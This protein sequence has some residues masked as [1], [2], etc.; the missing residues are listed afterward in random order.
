MFYF[1]CNHGLRPKLLFVWRGQRQQRFMS[2]R[3]QYCHDWRKPEF[4]TAGLCPNFRRRARTAPPI[5]TGDCGCPEVTVTRRRAKK[6]RP[7]DDRSTDSDWPTPDP[8]ADQ[9]CRSIAVRNGLDRVTTYLVQTY[10]TD[11]WGYPRFW[12]YSWRIYRFFL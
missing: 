9:V 6:T 5:P 2:M 11:T 1:T 10:T 3:S 7:T 4:T 12:L 8:L